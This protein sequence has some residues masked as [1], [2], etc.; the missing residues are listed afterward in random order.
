MGKEKDM[1]YNL[2]KGR[3][4]IAIYDKDDFLIDVVSTVK[5]LKNS[6]LE[7]F[8][9][10]LSRATRGKRQTPAKYFLIDCLEEHDDCFQEEDK[11]FL[12]FSKK[13]SRKEIANDLGISY[14]TFLR[15][16]KTM[17]ELCKD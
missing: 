1:Q 11:K 4:L 5:E 14:R 13:K 6:N 2:Y 17:G 9:S 10:I 12:E 15:R 16:K 7:T 8:A 3:Y